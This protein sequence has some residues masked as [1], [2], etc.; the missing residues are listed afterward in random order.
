LFAVV[1]LK[2]LSGPQKARSYKNEIFISYAH[3]DNESAFQGQNGWIS[4]FHHALEIRVA[5]LLGRKP[6]VWRDP[7]LTGNDQFADTITDQLPQTAVLVTVLSPRYVKSEWCRREFQ[8]F[9]QTCTKSS[10]VALGN[11]SRIFK[12]VKT[13]VPNLPDDTDLQPLL[14]P[15]LGYDFFKLDPDTG[16]FHELDLAF[17]PEAKADYWLRL[18][19]LAQDIASLLEKMMSGAQKEQ[20]TH[21]AV[22]LAETS[23]DVKEQAISVRRDLERRGYPVYPNRQLPLEKSELEAFV[24]EQL[25]LCAMSV[26][27]GGANYGVVPDGSIQSIVEIQHELAVEYAKSRGVVR[28]VWLPPAV[29]PQDERQH[30]FVERLRNDPSWGK[31][32]DLLETSVESLKTAIDERLAILET[33][34]KKEEPPAPA[35]DAQPGRVY[36][37]CDQPDLDNLRPLSDF[38]FEQ[39]IEVILPLFEGS[40]ADLRLEHEENLA[41]CDAAI[42]YHGQT[43]DLFLR[44]K[45]REL[46]KAGESSRL[47]VRAVCLAPPATPDKQSFRTL[48][49]TVIEQTSGFSPGSWTPFLSQLRTKGVTA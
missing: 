39:G 7:K 27:L 36:L 31:D 20:Q 26:H 1:Y 24:R 15:L 45:L 9:W 8:S 13:P 3:I 30:K 42:I 49:A 6:T 40:E 16:K 11:K 44:R 22:Y 38:L 2:V 21:P 35:R 17:G 43:H 34:P 37:I 32:A 48:E 12:V 18:D 41:T 25:S 14:Q 10:G 23:A 4:D 33:P 47:R 5:Q 19:D 46:K 29:Q 28:L